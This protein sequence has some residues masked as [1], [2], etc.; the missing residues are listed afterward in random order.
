MIDPPWDTDIV[1]YTQGLANQLAV[2]GIRANTVS[3]G[4]A[5]FP[6]GGVQH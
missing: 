4:N 1:H 3:P 2:R 5:L 6:G